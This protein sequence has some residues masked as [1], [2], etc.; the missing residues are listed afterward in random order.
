MTL[1]AN[2]TAEIASL[3]AQVKA[4]G[5]L[6]AA[7]RATVQAIKLNAAQLV[8]DTQAALVAP[9]NM[10]DTWVPPVDPAAIVTGILSV[11]QASEDQ[12]D[13]AVTRGIVGRVA[14]NVDQV[15]T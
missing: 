13:L 7:P 2:I 12:S 4:A 1:P 10:L 9:H 3:Q 14:S 15:A 5:A 6:N 11:A 8:A